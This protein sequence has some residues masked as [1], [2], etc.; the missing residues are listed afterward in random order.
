MKIRRLFIKK[1]RVNSI[2][3]REYDSA[4]IFFGFE[5]TFVRNQPLVKGTLDSIDLVVKDDSNSQNPWLRELEIKLTAL[6]DN[7]TCDL[8]DG[9]I[10]L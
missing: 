8:S 6:P 1:S 10:W 5:S 7:S 4:D 9:T 3:G 2:F